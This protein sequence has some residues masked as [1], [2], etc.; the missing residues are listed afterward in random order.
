MSEADTP[1][2]PSAAA[3]RVSAEQGWSSPTVG[4]LGGLGPMATATFL[5]VL[6]DLTP[7]ARDQDHLDLVVLSHAT[8]PD[9]TARIL[10]DSAPDPAP[11]LEADARRLQALGVDF[12]VMPCNTGHWFMHAIEGS[13][14]VPVLSIVQE[15][16]A[17]GVAAAQ[18]HGRPPRIGVLATD[19]TRRSEVYSRQIQQAGGEPVLPTEADQRAVMSIIY[20]QVKA[21]LPGDPKALSEIAG[22][23]LDAG[24]DV[25]LLAC[26]ELSVVFDE[27]RMGQ[28]ARLV[29]GLDSVARATLRRAGREPRIGG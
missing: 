20:D 19:G 3:L 28:D 8:T 15:T 29:D 26:T 16:V 23:L 6:T 12:V 18:A 4:V 11:V 13:V 10:D 5:K 7:A 17:A 1:L 22:R 2:D 24:A 9:R 21:G 14:Q 27:H 25:V